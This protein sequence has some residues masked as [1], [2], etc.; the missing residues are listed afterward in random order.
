MIYE[1]LDTAEH[2]L[3]VLGTLEDLDH[4][5][6]QEN[7]SCGGLPTKAL[8]I[9][10]HGHAPAFVKGSALL[11]ALGSVLSDEKMTPVEF[12]EIR[13]QLARLLAAAS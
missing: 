13:A 4:R 5:E 6:H 7:C 10:M 12:R 8:K 2:P 9:T 3:V 1:L 11:V